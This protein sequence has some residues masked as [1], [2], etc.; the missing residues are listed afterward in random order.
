MTDEELE[1]VVNHC[2]TTLARLSR[3]PQVA[4]RRYWRHR[5]RVRR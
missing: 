4:G 5:R 2:F 3:R 1:W